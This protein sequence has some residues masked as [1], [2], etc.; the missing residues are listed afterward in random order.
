MA[1]ET[2]STKWLELAG[3]RTLS[4]GGSGVEH[5]PSWPPE[6]GPVR[7]F[8]AVQDLTEASVLTAPVPFASRACCIAINGH[9]IDD[10]VSMPINNPRSSFPICVRWADVAQ[11][12]ASLLII[13]KQRLK[14]LSRV[15]CQCRLRPTLCPRSKFGRIQTSNANGASLVNDSVAIQN[16][17]ESWLWNASDV[18]E[19]LK[20][21]HTHSCD[22]P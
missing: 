20:L 21:S 18:I 7:W 19:R 1:P 5:L 11:L 22:K 13:R 9:V 14:I 17:I 3:K 16:P 15:A 4:V 8:V 6:A 10:V 12:P 2:L